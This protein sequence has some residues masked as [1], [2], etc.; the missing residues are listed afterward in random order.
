M[1]LVASRPAPLKSLPEIYPAQIGQLLLDSY[2]EVLGEPGLQQALRMVNLAPVGDPS[3]TTAPALPFETPALLA[4]AIEEIHGEQTGRGLC[5]RAG[6]VM[7]RRGIRSFSTTLGLTDRGFR[8][9]PPAQKISRGLDLLAWL[10]N[11][12]SDQRVHVEKTA[13]HIL[14]V[15]ERCPHCWNR[16]L[17]RPAC[18]LPSGALQEGLSWASAGK[19]FAVE[20]ITCRAKG[21]PACTF[22]ISRKPL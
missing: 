6:R 20:E 19:R 14:L 8:L 3:Q 15:N 16:H 9:M 10:L 4:Q 13:M 2:K 5:L 17:D 11:H 21:D 12:Y 22:Q 1:D 18:L 7:F